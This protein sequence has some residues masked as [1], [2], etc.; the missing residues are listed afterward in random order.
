[1]QK[2]ADASIT[3]RN[4]QTASAHAATRNWQDIV[5]LLEKHFP[6]AAAPDV[7]MRE[8]EEGTPPPV[9]EEGDATAADSSSPGGE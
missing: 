7:A 9:E 3:D 5:E 6:S 8:A 4:G 2:G 1:L